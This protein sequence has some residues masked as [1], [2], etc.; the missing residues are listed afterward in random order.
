MK[1]EEEGNISYII[2]FQ[3]TGTKIRVKKNYHSQG[4]AHTGTFIVLI[5]Q[6][7]P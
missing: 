5:S 7:E 6:P 4:N 1:E 3:S 2:F